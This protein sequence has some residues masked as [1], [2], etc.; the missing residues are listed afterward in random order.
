MSASETDPERTPEFDRDVVIVGGGPAGCSA[1]IFIARYGL[2]AVIFDRG[3]SSIQR[4]AHLENYLGF[5]AGIDIGTLYGLMH[6]HAEEAGCEI[7]PDMVE[8]IEYRDDDEGFVVG[9]Q[10]GRRVTAGRVVAASRYDGEFLRPLGDESMF[11]TY[12]YDGEEHERFDKG[13]SEQDGTTPIDGLFV[14]SPAEGI[15]YQAI[16]AAGRGARVGIEVVEDVRRERG[17]PE[18]V[19]NHYDWIR[20]ESELA[21]EWSDPD[22]WREYFEDRLPEDHD[23]EAERRVALREREIDRR[24]ETYIEREEMERRNRRGLERL[25]KHVDD[26]LILERAAEIEAGRETSQVGH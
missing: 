6:D 26:E 4:C 13:Y 8:S 20:R 18:P 25:L 14:A 15:D 19:S 7:V 21:G 17:L 10:E 3:R 24:L 5:P 12:E 1:G 16:M 11:T 22:R 23:I 2:D 9:T